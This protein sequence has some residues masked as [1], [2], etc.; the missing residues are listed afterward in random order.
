MRQAK[1]LV[2]GSVKVQEILLGPVVCALDWHTAV[3]VRTIVSVVRT[4]D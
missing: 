4:S 3:R 1:P 2:L